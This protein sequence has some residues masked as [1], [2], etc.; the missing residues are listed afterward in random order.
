MKKSL[1]A[2]AAMGAFAGAAQAQSS[3][4]VYGIY[5][6]GYSSSNLKESIG[7]TKTNTQTSGY[8]GGESA[9]SRIGFRGVEDLGGGLSANFNL[10]LGITAGTG[11]V[12]VTTVTTGATQ[13]S[14]SAS[15]RTSIVGISSKQYGSLAVGRQLT[16]MHAILAGDVWGGN[17]MAGDITYS[18]TASTAAGAGATA[19]GRIN[20][21]TTRSSNMLTYTSPTFMGAS[22]R[23]DH[24]NT[25]ST[26]LNQPGEQY[27]ITGG[28]LA[29]T[30]GKITAKAGQVK[31]KSNAAIAS[32][33]AFSA[34]QTVVNGANIMYR[35][36]G[37]T[38]QYTIGNNKTE[39]LNATATTLASNVKAQKISASYQL[40][41]QIMP[42]VQYGRG[43]TEGLR[44][45]GAASTTTDDSAYQ[46]GVEY[47]MSKR[48]SL[49]GAYG[50]SNRELKSNGA[51]KTEYTDYAL[52][53]RHTF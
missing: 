22:L 9:T 34:S 33:T 2:L 48:T 3:V 28:Y 20:S 18:G 29:Y 4:T 51:N 36:K 12:G 23:L 49:Y 30:Y 47:A 5:D 26:A 7:A 43:G 17:N 32:G 50:V 8:T 45:V 39:T 42:F 53:V 37:L 52:G 14:D 44:T 6:G 13:G 31:A 35:D 40:T 25:E 21:V 27:A 46:L 10:E 38:V 24:G 19:S 1:L 41:P 11:T 15:V 16:G